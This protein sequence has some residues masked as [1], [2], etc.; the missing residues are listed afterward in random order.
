MNYT[1][2]RILVLEDNEEQSSIY[3]H[4]FDELG[5]EYVIVTTYN[6]IRDLITTFNPN[7][8][9]VN[10][11]FKS[12]HLDG[13]KIK[14]YFDPSECVICGDHL[15]SDIV[16]KCND[17]GFFIIIETP[18][19]KSKLVK[20][21]NILWNLKDAKNNLVQTLNDKYRTIQEHDIILKSMNAGTYIKDSQLRYKAVNNVFLDMLGL[22]RDQVIG[23]TDDEIVLDPYKSKKFAM[24]DNHILVSKEPLSDIIEFT[25]FNN[26]SKW[27]ST[28]KSPYLNIDGEVE[29]ILGLIVD[30][31]SFVEIQQLLNVTFN[32]ILD[33]L[34]I[35]NDE[36]K[37]THYNKTFKHWHDFNGSE[38]LT[39][40]LCSDFF[41]CDCSNDFDRCLAKKT[42]ND[43]T[44]E[45]Q[46]MMIDGR[47]YDVRYYPII[48]NNQTSSVI[49]TQRDIHGVKIREQKLEYRLKL[50]RLLVN[51][52]SSFAGLNS[53]DIDIG[54]N[55]ALEDI[56]EFFELPI[57]CV[58]KIDSTRKLLQK[59]NHA[60]QKSVVP[61]L[62]VGNILNIE[63]VGTTFLHLL[64]SGPFISDN[65]PQTIS[66]LMED[67]QLHSSLV[68][69]ITKSGNNDIIGFL[70]ADNAKTFSWDTD[71]VNLFQV[72]GDLF[73]SAF[74]RRSLEEEL[75][76]QRQLKENAIAQELHS[77]KEESKKKFTKTQDNID[78][79]SSI[80]NDVVRNKKRSTA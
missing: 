46:E 5:I 75:Y 50:E 59:T 29:E 21:L 13:L 69:P 32:S 65:T 72:I 24:Q 31:T 74:T 49:I 66:C 48:Q 39:G 35:I 41:E 8:A 15:E 64:K 58:F 22:P 76:V 53:K 47:W 34:I 7:L 26:T 56:I 44:V 43:K 71:I 25:N 45:Q 4:L 38:S 19:T 62:R 1:G 68:I 79:L 40:R 33:G 78:V 12:T 23:K 2:L 60:Y 80:I 27:T 9:I 11:N 73:G 61:K 17:L 55:S 54:I 36:F 30:I 18:I 37:I 70:C 16:S 20:C 57:A 77:W 63:C 28:F 10:L 52:S 14:N 6:D 42:F 67:S 3:K 51:I